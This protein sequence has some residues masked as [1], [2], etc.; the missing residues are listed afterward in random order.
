[1]NNKPRK[2]A[3][4]LMLIAIL[5]AVIIPP[6]GISIVLGFPVN[7]A[8]SKVLTWGEA[9]GT[10]IIG[11]AGGTWASTKE[12][13][14]KIWASIIDCAPEWIT[15]I[16]TSIIDC[17]IK[18]SEFFIVTIISLFIIC[19][20]PFLLRKHVESIRESLSNIQE[21]IGEAFQGKSLPWKEIFIESLKLA[22]YPLHLALRLIARFLLMLA[23]FTTFLIPHLIVILFLIY[24]FSAIQEPLSNF[25]Q[26][27]EKTF[28][29]IYESLTNKTNDIERYIDHLS[30][31]S[32]V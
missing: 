20:I 9:A 5:V 25:L 6:I 23:I 4:F 19:L 2:I 24:I 22:V 12:W 29:N 7:W 28:T 17:A 31:F 27:I 3:R 14:T 13:I 32:P 10:W 1:M 15:K 11:W 18:L 16:W 26:P 8:W 30:D 21:K